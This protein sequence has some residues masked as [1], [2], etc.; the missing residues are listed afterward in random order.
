M[1]IDECDRVTEQGSFPQLHS[2]LDAVEKANPMDDSDDEGDASDP[3]DEM[4]DDNPDRD[5]DFKE[6][7][8]KLKIDDEDYTLLNDGPVVSVMYR[9][10]GVKVY[11]EDMEVK[12]CDFIEAAKEQRA[13]HERAEARKNS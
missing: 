12:I 2:I 6:L 4:D 1:V 3:E 5:T 13:D 9:L 8:L 10:N 11:G 7:M